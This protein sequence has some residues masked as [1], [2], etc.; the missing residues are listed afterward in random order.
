MD[1]TS[2]CQGSIVDAVIS[3]ITSDHELCTICMSGS[4]TL[5]DGTADE[6]RCA[7]IGAFNDSGHLLEEWH[8]MTTEMYPNDNKLLALIP[9]SAD[10]CPTKLIGGF[11][12]HKKCATA[13]KTCIMLWI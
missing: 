2:R 8:N 3:I 9:N 10:M 11:L 12:G 4:I 5:K 1:E 7:I 13:N 6:Q